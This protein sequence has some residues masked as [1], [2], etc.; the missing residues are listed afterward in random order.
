MEKEMLSTVLQVLGQLRILHWQ[1]ESYAEH[2]AFEKTY[3]ALSDHFDKIIEVYSGKNQRPKFGGIKNLAFSD[4]DNVKVDTFV[5]PKTTI[6]PPNGTIIPIPLA[7][8]VPTTPKVTP[9]PYSPTASQGAGASGGF[10]AVVAAAMNKPY[11]AGTSGVNTTT[12][13]GIMAASGQPLV[14]V[15]I[16][17]NVEDAAI[18]GIMNRSILNAWRAV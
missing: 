14:A 15:T 6:V 9:V 5:P 17:K 13:A 11:S 10:S 8:I 7:P 2:K 1:T 3:K 16:N 12:L 18:E 4:Y